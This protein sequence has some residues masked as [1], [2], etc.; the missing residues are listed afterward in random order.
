MSQNTLKTHNIINI[1]R[2][3][4]TLIELLV[5]IAIIAILAAM[6]LPALQRARDNAK[7]ISCV[8]NLK[9]TS[10]ALLM[11]AGDNREYVI[12]AG[13]KGDKM[14]ARFLGTE[15]NYL[16]G[17]P[18]DPAT[19]AKPKVVYGYWTCPSARILPSDDVSLL[20]RWNSFGLPM[21]SAAID[22]S[23]A[24]GHSGYADA[25][26]RHIP[27]FKKYYSDRG[28][29]AILVGESARQDGGWGAQCAMISNDGTGVLAT[30]AKSFNLNLNHSG[31]TITNVALLDGH[32]ESWTVGNIAEQWYN[33]NIIQ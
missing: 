9:Q 12:A 21:G 19:G 10:L 16:P 6:L 13:L 23:V 15:T 2:R 27:R 31:N 14:W 11:Y 28:K 5:V 26:F 32:V 1:M 33:Y 25:F 20:A 7:K 18:A 29:L 30:T 22:G 17:Y 24:G 8:N 3:K 4:F